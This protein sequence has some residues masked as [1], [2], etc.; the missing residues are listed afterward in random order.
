MKK[1]IHTGIAKALKK[2]VNTLSILEE[3][4]FQLTCSQNYTELKQL[5]SRVQNFLVLYTPLTKHLLCMCWFQLEIQFQYDPVFEYNKAIE[6]FLNHYY[7]SPEDTFKI[8]FQL[9]LFFK[10]YAEF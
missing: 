9:S 1:K 4:I 10:E 2:Q 5:L 7:P 6:R 3:L 8:I